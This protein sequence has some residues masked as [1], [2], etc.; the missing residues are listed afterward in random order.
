MYMMVETSAEI[1]KIN[2]RLEGRM[3]SQAPLMS[4]VTFLKSIALKTLS[5]F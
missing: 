4:A 5:L 3:T 2:K 1:V